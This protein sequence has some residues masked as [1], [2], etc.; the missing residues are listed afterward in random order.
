MQMRKSLMVGVA[1]LATLAIPSGVAMAQGMSQS[2]TS[3]TTVAPPPVVVT[4]APVVVAPPPGTLSVSH[5]QA[6]STSD[7]TQS[8]TDQ[9]TYQNSNGVASDS[10]SKST[11]YPPAIVQS[12]KKTTTTITP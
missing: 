11:T 10:V 4:P 7:G 6:T 1:T 5:S 3:T 9:T 12:T 8:R 2:T